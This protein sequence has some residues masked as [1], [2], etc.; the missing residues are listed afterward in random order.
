MILEPRPRCHGQAASAIAHT[1]RRLRAEG[2]S[3]GLRI[4]GSVTESW[5]SMHM[6]LGSIPST[7]KEGGWIN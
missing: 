6:V 5:P 4:Y 1:A 7:K 3:V 2:R